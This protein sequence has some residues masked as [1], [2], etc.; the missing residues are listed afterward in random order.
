MVYRDDGAMDVRLSP[1]ARAGNWLPT[2]ARPRLKVALR[3]YD[4][5]FSFTSGAAEA[6]GLP[7]ITR[8]ACQ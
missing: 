3:L 8:E 7:R 5:P 6:S 1:R 4:A 2:G